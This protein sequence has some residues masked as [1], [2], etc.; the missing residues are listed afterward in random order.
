[1]VTPKG[2]GWTNNF[3]IGTFQS[4][5]AWINKVDDFMF[6]EVKNED[7]GANFLFMV[8]NSAIETTP[9]V[10]NGPGGKPVAESYAMAPGTF[11]EVKRLVKLP[12]DDVKVEAGLPPEDKKYYPMRK[13][14]FYKEDAKAPDTAVAPVAPPVTPPVA[15]PVTPPATTPVTPPPTADNGW[16]EAPLEKPVLVSGNQLPVGIGVGSADSDV[17]AAGAS[18][19]LTAKQFDSLDV[20]P[21][22]DAAALAELPKPGNPIQQLM[23]PA[24]KRMVQVQLS[25][26]AGADSWAWLPKLAEFTVVDA[27]GTAYK[28]S[29]VLGLAGPAG[30]TQKLL[31]VYRATGELTL[32][33]VENAPLTSLT[34]VYLIP[35]DQKATE[36]RYQGK[37][38][39]LPLEK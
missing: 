30:P 38:G 14:A 27:T 5:K 12:L 15:P 28:P 22:N 36:L 13:T 35:A 32:K 26:K 23:V 39:G 20:D 37:A 19:H 24:G 11:I 18:G 1:L 16:G 31:A 6:V 33:K 25:I 34:F 17:L 21:S 10:K 3:P 9:A 8:D 7:R 2:D 4:G 29:G